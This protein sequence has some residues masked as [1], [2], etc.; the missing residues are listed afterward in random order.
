MEERRRKERTG[1]KELG[2]ESSMEEK[3]GRMSRGIY[4]EGKKAKVGAKKKL[5]GRQEKGVKGEG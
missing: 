3:K 5:K 2:E 1:M 4:L